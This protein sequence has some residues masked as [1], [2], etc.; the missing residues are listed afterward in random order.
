MQFPPPQTIAEM[1][2]ELTDLE[3]EFRYMQLAL[4][5]EAG[6]APGRLIEL[7]YVYAM[8]DNAGAR[9][10]DMH[11]LTQ[12]LADLMRQSRA[13]VFEMMQMT[14]NAVAAAEAA[15]RDRESAA[16]SLRL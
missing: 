12:Q 14:S 16:R 8:T 10:D 3:G 13:K 7:A 9:G 6:S 11:Q 4:Q 2:H 5:G 1:I 15:D